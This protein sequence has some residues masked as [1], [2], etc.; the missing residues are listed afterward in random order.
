MF[1]QNDIVIITAGIFSGCMGYVDTVATYEN[2]NQEL[3]VKIQEG[4]SLCSNNEIR[5][6]TPD[7]IKWE[8]I[9]RLGK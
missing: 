6:A 5:L 9:G 1:N 2:G 4:F 3:T 8:L 7:E